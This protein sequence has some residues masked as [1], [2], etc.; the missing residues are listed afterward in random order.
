[1]DKPQGIPVKLIAL[2]AFGVISTAHAGDIAAGKEKVLFVCSECHG[3]TGISDVEN[4][5]NLAGQKEMYLANQLK[6]FKSGKRK[7]EDM[8]PVAQQLTDADIAN[9][10][11]FYAS[12]H[13]SPK[14]EER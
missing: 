4:F 5:P 6:A 1:M 9:V 12:L 8:S 14:R 11:A 2:I 3:M 13:Y 10:A 7:N